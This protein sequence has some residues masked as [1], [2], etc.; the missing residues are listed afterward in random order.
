MVMSSIYTFGLLK[1]GYCFSTPYILQMKVQDCFKHE[2]ESILFCIDACLCDFCSCTNI[3]PHFQ[4]SNQN[5][6]GRTLVVLFPDRSS[7]CFLL[8]CPFICMWLGSHASCLTLRAVFW[9]HVV[10][11]M[12]ILLSGWQCC[13]CACLFVCVCVC[14]HQTS[15]SCQHFGRSSVPNFKLMP[16]QWMWRGTVY[17]GKGRSFQLSMLIV[18]FKYKI[19]VS[20]V[21]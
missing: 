6:D 14:V 8:K 5:P 7:P 20:L 11:H 4:M 10:Q 15:N 2:N 21:N 12:P 3:W 19:R 13:V 18:S 1:I 16:C 17:T 9:V